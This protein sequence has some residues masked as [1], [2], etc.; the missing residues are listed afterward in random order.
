MFV[1]LSNS[2]VESLTLIWWYLSWGL[3]EVIRL[4]WGHGIG[5]LIRKEGPE[6]FLSIL[7]G[8]SKR[9]YLCKPGRG[10]FLET[11]SAGTLILNFSAFRTLRNKWLL[12]KKNKTKNTLFSS[13]TDPA[14]NW[15][16]SKVS[17]FSM[18]WSEV[19]VKVTQ[20]C[21][22]LCDLMDY[23]V[24]ETLQA[25]ILEWIA[26]P[27]PRGSSQSR[28]RTQVS[29]IAGRFFTSWATREAKLKCQSFTKCIFWPDRAMGIYS[30]V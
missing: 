25:R 2:Y 10:F 22:T 21:P 23:I 8:Y 5:T 9:V 29:H 19:K 14:N 24:H 28:D 12:F 27:F 4:R 17:Y 13:S 7:W 6:L 3:W 18:N 26:I 1:F 20:L 11:E 30:L 15:Q 16:T